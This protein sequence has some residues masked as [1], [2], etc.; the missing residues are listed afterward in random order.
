MNIANIRP[1]TVD[2]IKN[3]AKQIKRERNI[4]HTSA[5]AIASQQAGFESFPH[6]RKALSAAISQ[7]LFP[8]YLSIHWQERRSGAINESALNSQAIGGAP[9]WQFGREILRVNLSRPLPEI[10]TKQRVGWARGLAGFTMEYADHLERR[11]L[12]NSQ[13]A[14][15]GFLVSAERC[16]RFMEASKLQPISQQALRNRL[17][18]LD[19][20]P[21]RD[22]TS[23][24]FDPET[25]AVAMLDEPYPDALADHVAAR[26]Q[27]LA[28]HGFTEVNLPWEGIHNPGQAVAI[29][30]SNDPA[31]LD[32]VS[33]AVARLPPYVIPDPWVIETGRM[34]DAF[35]SPKRTEDGKARRPIP[36]RSYAPRMGAIPYGGGFGVRSRWRPSQTMRPELHMELGALIMQIDDIELSDKVRSKLRVHYRSELENWANLEHPGSDVGY[37]AYYGQQKLKYFGSRVQKLAALARA[38]AIVEEGYN[39]CKPR[40]ELLS[41]IDAFIVGIKN[42]S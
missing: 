20:L 25:D 35:V 8:V 41:A 14:A 27:W 15:R 3:L 33:K 40:R 28:N 23:A 37:E 1:S 30:V 19:E 34:G 29:L 32:R 26:T 24:W 18:A 31:L 2:G 17:R 16:L 22:H 42:L 12:A 9:R 38:R 36:D 10:I 39:D 4:S 11:T 21:G 13:Q 6:A 5:L 7:R